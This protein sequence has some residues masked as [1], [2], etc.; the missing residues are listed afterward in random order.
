MTWIFKIYQDGEVVAS[1]EAPDEVSASIKA[2]NY[3]NEHGFKF[4]IDV[5]VKRRRGRRGRNRIANALQGTH[6]RSGK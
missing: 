5:V 2:H 1:G 3:A 6:E 4:P